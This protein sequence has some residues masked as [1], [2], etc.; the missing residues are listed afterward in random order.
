MKPQVGEVWHIDHSRKGPL[1]IKVLDD[2]SA[3]TFFSGEV[4]EGK[5]RYASQ[6]NRDA[7]RLN[8]QG[9]SGDVIRMRGEFTRF[10]SRVE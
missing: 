7:Q 5:V 3:D 1:I 6:S 8:G 2:P 10:V 9:T 4:V